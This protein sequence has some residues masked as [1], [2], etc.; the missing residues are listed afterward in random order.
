MRFG[1]VK[2]KLKT[3]VNEINLKNQFN[4]KLL[5][6]IESILYDTNI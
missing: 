6:M 4:G 5:N 2:R 3:M 1:V